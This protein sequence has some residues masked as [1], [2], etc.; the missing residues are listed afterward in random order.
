METT[1]ERA[2]RIGGRCFDVALGV[3]LIAVLAMVWNSSRARASSTTGD[4]SAVISETGAAGISALAPL[5]GTICIVDDSNG[6]QI[7]FDSTGAYI[8]TNCSTVTLTGQG[9]FATK[10]SII[11]LKDVKA[12]RRLDLYLDTSV[13]RASLGLTLFSPL[14]FFTIADRNTANDV[15]GCTITV[16]PQ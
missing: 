5:Q 7:Q 13:K 4:P 12:D 10:G 15:C 6:N 16:R 14:R 11:T 8:F 3:F 1:R 2:K 9:V